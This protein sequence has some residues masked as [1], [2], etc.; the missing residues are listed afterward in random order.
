MLVYIG[1]V[2]STLSA[3]IHSMEGFDKGFREEHQTGA[4][5]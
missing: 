2:H 1:G 4:T 5:C 3:R